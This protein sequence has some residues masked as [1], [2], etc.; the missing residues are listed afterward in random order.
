MK[1]IMNKAKFTGQEYN[2]FLK[3]QAKEKKAG[4]KSAKK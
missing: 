2:D 3:Q 4:K 1:D